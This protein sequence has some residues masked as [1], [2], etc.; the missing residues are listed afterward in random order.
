MY[1]LCI[2]FW[3]SDDIYMHYHI[4][5]KLISCVYFYCVI[6]CV[7]QSILNIKTLGAYQNRIM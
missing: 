4:R 1:E 2:I 6:G 3:Y 5:K 7:L